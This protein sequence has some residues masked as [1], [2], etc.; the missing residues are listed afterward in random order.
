MS[1]PDAAAITLRQLQYIVEVARLGGFRRAATACHVSQPALSAQVALAERQ[2][3]VQIFER[4]RR[5]V[6]VSPA[7]APLVE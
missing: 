2:L 4:N 6:R 7:G 5:S 1:V 3:G